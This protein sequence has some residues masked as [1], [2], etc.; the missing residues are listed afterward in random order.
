MAAL[1]TDTL[2]AIG[3]S[4]ASALPELID[5][6]RDLHAHPELARH[7][8][9]TTDTVAA[10]LERA[11]VRVRRLTGTGLV[12]EVGAEQ[13]AYRVALRA[14]MDALPVQESTGLAF[15]S[16]TDG[17]AHACGHDVHVTALLG[18]ML[19]LKELEQDL[20]E[21]GTAVRGIFQAAEE[22]M[23]ACANARDGVMECVDASFATAL[24]PS[25]TSP[26]RFRE[27]GSRLLRTTSVSS[28]GR[29]VHTSRP[30]DEDLPLR[31][32]R[33]SPRA[34]PCP[35]GSTARRDGP[36][37]ASRAGR[38]ATSPYSGS[39]RRCGCSNRHLA[40]VGR[41][42]EIV[43]RSLPRRRAGSTIKGVPP[44][45]TRPCPSTRWGCLPGSGLQ[46]APT[47][48]SL[49]VRTTRGTP[50]PRP[51]PWRAWHAHRPCSTFASTGYVSST[52]LRRCGRPPRLL[53]FAHTAEPDDRLVVALPPLSDE[54]SMIEIDWD[55]C[56]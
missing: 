47:L 26:D 5:F 55:A 7:E 32:P 22:V 51:V 25:L 31:S 6:R 53:F 2:T 13:P 28:R 37:W 4:V 35:A 44:V 9:R 12:A 23:P 8:Y 45:S 17:V 3:A 50:P 15:A 18:A 27:G 34:G 19:T 39:E 11:G 42:C 38:R 14:D 43:Q 24:R 48:Q 52:G 10:R 36:L 1:M 46:V 21:R 54:S 33:S 16:T 40:P 20:R 30:S 41:C 56:G 49:G 29:G